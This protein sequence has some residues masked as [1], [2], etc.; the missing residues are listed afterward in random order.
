[1]RQ[2]KKYGTGGRGIMAVLLPDDAITVRVDRDLYRQ[3]KRMKRNDEK[4]WEVLDRIIRD[5][6][7]YAQLKGEN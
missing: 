7:N 2:G 5:G 1:M 4:D 6:I 3:V